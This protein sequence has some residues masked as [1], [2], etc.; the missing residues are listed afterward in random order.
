MNS[1]LLLRAAGFASNCTRNHLA[2]SIVFFT[3]IYGYSLYNI[4]VHTH[5]YIHTYILCRGLQPQLRMYYIGC[6]TKSSALRIYI[7]L[8]RFYTQILLSYFTDRAP[9]RKLDV[10]IPVR[11]RT[12]LYNNTYACWSVIQ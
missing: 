7:L 4:T 3:N 9:R 5:T 2:F 6:L 10:F 8:S 11:Y 1:L 12:Y